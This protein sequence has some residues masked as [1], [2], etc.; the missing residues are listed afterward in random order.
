MMEAL[1]TQTWVG[2]VGGPGETP[3]MRNILGEALSPESMGEVDGTDY[4]NMFLPG[5]ISQR[6]GD[7]VM[8]GLVDIDFPGHKPSVRQEGVRMLQY[9]GQKQSA[10]PIVGEW[11]G[12]PQIFSVPDPDWVDDEGLQPYDYWQ[13]EVGRVKLEGVS[14]RR[15]TLRESLRELFEG[16]SGK[17]KDFAALNDDTPGNRKIKREVVA[18]IISAYRAVAYLNT[19]NHKNEDGSLAYAAWLVQIDAARELMK[20]REDRTAAGAGEMAEERRRSARDPQHT[21]L[22]VGT[23]HRDEVGS[24]V[25]KAKGRP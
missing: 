10:A 1:R 17:A 20:P 11:T 8:E 3:I 7:L 25:E 9:V 14:G 12:V 22:G 19:K 13:R 2:I 4:L 6:T 18:G 15:V 21:T 16:K 24:V 5:R 23:K